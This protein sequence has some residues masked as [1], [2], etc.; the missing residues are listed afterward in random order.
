MASP[1]KNKPGELLGLSLAEAR[2]LILGTLCT[3]E[4]GKVDCEKLARKGNYKNAASAGTSYRTAKR[5]LNDL[6]PPDSQDAAATPSPNQSVATPKKG[7]GK[8]KKDDATPGAGNDASPSK[9]KR[10]KKT[11]ATPVKLK[12]S[13]SEDD[14]DVINP[15]LSSPTKARGVK[16]GKAQPA[17]P[18]KLESTTA[19]TP[20]SAT[21][22][23]PVVKAEEGD[24][25]LMVSSDDEWVN[26]PLDTEAEWNAM[27]ENGRVVEP[28]KEA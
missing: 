25:G 20:M 24:S 7:K 10:Q 27:E 5:K 14:N 3:D 1:V 19:D 13:D 11:A 12:N 8:A 6:N 28:K 9:P 26:K 21:K 23:G 16:P 4:S 22:V 17:T 18:V 2:L 15:E